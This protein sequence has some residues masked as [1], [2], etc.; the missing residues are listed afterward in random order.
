VI[1]RLSFNA[2]A[3]AA[4]PARVVGTDQPDISL[5]NQRR[6]LERLAGFFLG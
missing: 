6:G 4:V 5:V 3:A 2:N 1:V